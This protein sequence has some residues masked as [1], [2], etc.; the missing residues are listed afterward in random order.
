MT[1]IKNLDHLES[2][3]VLLFAVAIFIWKPG[4]YVASGLICLYLILRTAIEV[5]FRNTLWNSTLAKLS[6]G[7]Y[8]V[9]LIT[10]TLGAETYQDV[11]WM[12]RKTLFLPIV[13]FL[14]FALKRRVN[15]QLAMTGLVIGFWIASVITLSNHDWQLNYA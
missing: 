12:A 15:Q 3:C 8:A 2:F 13:V 7:M 1:P 14:A 9:G 4:I 10:A 11:A 6:L 5:E